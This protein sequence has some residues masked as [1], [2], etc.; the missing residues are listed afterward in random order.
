MPGYK[1]INFEN[2]SPVPALVG[3]AYDVVLD[4]G[5]GSGNQLHRLKADPT[6]PRLWY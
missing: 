5:A 3:K 6:Q 4:L 1:F 2:S